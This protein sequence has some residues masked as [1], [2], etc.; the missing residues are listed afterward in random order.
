M[1]RI[2]TTDADIRHDVDR[3]LQ[4]APGYPDDYDTDAIVGEI[5][6]R[7]GV[8]CYADLPHDEF[9][10]IVARHDESQED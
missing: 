4:G 5:V 2:F 3:A 8:E 9:W 10:Q 6:E 1:A 7:V